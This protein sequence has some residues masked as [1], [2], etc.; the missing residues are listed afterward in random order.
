MA[1]RWFIGVD[2]KY[3]KFG[4]GK[5]LM[6]EVIIHCSSDHRPIYL[7]TSTM[8]NLTWYKKFGFVVYDT[9]ELSYKLYFLKRPL[10]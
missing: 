3:Q 1:Y 5:R 8:E 2:P 4:L 9:L 10:H 7:E 6:E